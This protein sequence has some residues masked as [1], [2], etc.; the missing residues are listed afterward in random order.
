VANVRT[1]PYR[2]RAEQL[3]AGRQ[4]RQRVRRSSQA[5][6]QASPDRPDPVVTLE[7]EGE[8][9]LPHLLPLRYQRMSESPFAFYRGGAGIMAIDLSHQPHSNVRTQLCGDMHLSNLG[10]YGSPE[11]VL[12]F[13]VNDF[14]ETLPGP[15]EWDVKRLAASFVIAGEH[16]GFT[17]KQSDKSVAEMVKA[18][19]LAIHETA[20][21]GVLD[22]WY[23]RISDQDLLSAVR[24][25]GAQKDQV[26][27]TARALNKARTR[28]SLSAAKKLTEVVDGKRRFREDPPL[29][30][31]PLEVSDNIDLVKQLLAK[32][33]RS[34]PQDRRQLFDRFTLVDIALKV[35]GVGSVGTRAWAI[36]LQ[37]RDEDDL[38]MLQAK[39]AG[40]SVL[41]PFLGV[42]AY[43]NHGQRVVEGQRLMQAAS[44]IF[45]G[46]VNNDENSIHFYVRQ[47]R[48]MKGSVEIDAMD[49]QAHVA[50]GRLCGTA[51]GLAHARA[52]GVAE[53]AGYVGESAT[54]DRAIIDFANAY[55]EQNQRDYRMF[56]DAISKGRLSAAA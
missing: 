30:T 20:G 32:Y 22:T 47:L 16:Q 6:Y 51:L 50:Y 29:L 21:S 27:K 12:L 23:S 2:T 38:L 14:D 33:R 3:A 40:M 56:M 8:S 5:N 19:R 54:L 1:R 44:D 10:V 24:M 4:A 25:M 52:G 42:S 31:H 18:Y 46:W 43:R 36:L 9:R 37:G 35:V 11:R 41:E 15:F 48:D 28:T 45:L 34:L 49:P 13:D 26:T 53:I 7:Q 17:Q 55:A 39:E